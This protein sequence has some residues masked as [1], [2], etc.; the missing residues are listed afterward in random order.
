MVPD[1]LSKDS[2]KVCRIHRPANGF[3]RGASPFYRVNRLGEGGT[4]RH[5]F[6][7]G[8]QTERKGERKNDN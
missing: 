4:R 7:T 2:Y 1:T 5:D 6:E 8:R 3:L